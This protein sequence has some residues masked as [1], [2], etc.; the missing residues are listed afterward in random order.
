MSFSQ[1]IDYISRCADLV[2][3]GDSDVICT[4]WTI[5][6]EKS[7]NGRMEQKCRVFGKWYFIG[8]KTI[9]VKTGL[10]QEIDRIKINI[11]RT[12]EIRNMY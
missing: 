6:A 9:S 12:K 11:N 7:K 8:V 5:H 1:G 3:H 4:I 2:S 10:I